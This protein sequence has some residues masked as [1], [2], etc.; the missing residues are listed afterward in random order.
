MALT[1]LIPLLGGHEPYAH[2]LATSHH[3]T[4]E[5]GEEFA[6]ALY[7]DCFSVLAVAAA[8]AAEVA[9]VASVPVMLKVL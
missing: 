8:T 4:A 2:C 3:H 5:A 6:S 9:Y 1:V 7:A